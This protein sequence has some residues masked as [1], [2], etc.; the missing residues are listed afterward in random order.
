MVKI[1][2]D[3]HGL[4]TANR[5]HFISYIGLLYGSISQGLGTTEFTNLIG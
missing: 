5:T 4:Q 1:G 3:R 2:I